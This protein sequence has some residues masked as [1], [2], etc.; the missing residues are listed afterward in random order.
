MREPSYWDL[1]PSILFVL[2]TLGMLINEIQRQKLHRQNQKMWKDHVA[3][4]DI[5]RRQH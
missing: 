3:R 4:M 2:F 1:A 5:A